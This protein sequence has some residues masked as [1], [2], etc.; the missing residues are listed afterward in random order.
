M[1]ERWFKHLLQ[2]VRKVTTPSFEKS[3]AIRPKMITERL[4]PL[5]R[6]LDTPEFRALFTPQLIKLNDL[7]RKN[8]FQLRMA[9]GAVRDLLMGIKPSDVD[10]ATDATPEQMKVST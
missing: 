6:K 9:G 8:D 2:Q 10:F 5:T 7:F 1:R 4:V 3:K